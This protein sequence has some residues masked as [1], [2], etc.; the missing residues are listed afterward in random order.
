MVQGQQVRRASDQQ[1]FDSIRNGLPGTDMSGFPMSDDDTWR[2]VAFV[3]SL[4]VSAAAQPVPGNVQAGSDIFWGRGG[5]SN[6]HSIRGQGGALGPDLTDIATVRRADQIKEAILKPNEAVPDGYRAVEA[7][8]ADGTKIKGVAKFEN[9]YTLR[10]LDRAGR[11]HFFEK[12]KLSGVSFPKGSLMPGNYA[13]RLSDD[14]L[15]NLLAF[16]SRQTLRKW[17]QE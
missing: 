15:A 7:T 17:E 11:L 16:L 8:R 12:K 13:E 1:L 5:C 6:C 14:E 2:V 9:N 10:V 3:R 4:G